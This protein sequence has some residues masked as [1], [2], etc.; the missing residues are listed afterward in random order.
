[1]T[2][3]LTNYNY[4]GPRYY[5][6]G[7]TILIQALKLLEQ[8][9]GLPVYLKRI[10]FQREV[11][12][13]GRILL[14]KDHDL[15]P[16]KIDDAH[17]YLVCRVDEVTWR[18]AFFEENDHISYRTEVAYGL[19]D[20]KHDKD[21]GGTCRICSSN[22]SE[23]IY[24]LVEANKRFHQGCLSTSGSKPSIRLG[25]IEDWQVP[26]ENAGLDTVL[27]S[28]N[29]ISQQLGPGLMTINRLSYTNSDGTKASLM[30][31]FNVKFE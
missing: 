9:W 18:G 25:Y 24:A 17:W 13:N 15:L 30:M 28:K 26:L 4:L 14:F 7:T 16:Y 2:T 11:I 1:M 27:Q 22:R 31:C 20:V 10:K 23:T 8:H 5:V 29:L 12:N 21:F 3:F 19:R 6:H